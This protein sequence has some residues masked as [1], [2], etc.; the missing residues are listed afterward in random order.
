MVLPLLDLT[1]LSVASLVLAYLTYIDARYYL[2]LDWANALLGI[3]GLIFITLHPAWHTSWWQPI[4]GAM[5]GAGIFW[6]T[7]RFSLWWQGIEGV[8]WGDVKFAAAAGIWLGP[9]GVGLMLLLSA[10]LLLLLGGTYAILVRRNVRN[11][12]LPFGVAGCPATALLIWGKAFGVLGP[13]AF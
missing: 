10:L 5:A 8:G 1:L 11:F 9:Q 3:L 2:L 12:Y 13:L 4:Y 7:Q 6:L